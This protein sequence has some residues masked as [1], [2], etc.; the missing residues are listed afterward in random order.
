MQKITV[1]MNFVEILYLQYDVVKK[2]PTSIK[3]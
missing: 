1:M 3:I 2:D